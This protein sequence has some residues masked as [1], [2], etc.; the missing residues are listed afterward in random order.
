MSRLGYIS[1]IM[2]GHAKPP[3]L[4][5]IEAA[6]KSIYRPQILQLAA[7]LAYL[8][9][10]TSLRESASL[11][12]GQ[13]S[14]NPFDHIELTPIQLRILQ[15]EPETIEIFLDQFSDIFD[16]QYGTTELKEQYSTIELTDRFINLSRLHLHAAAAVLT[17]G[18]D[19]RGAVQS[20]LLASELALKSG[21]A[22]EGLTETRL[23]PAS[24]TA[25]PVWPILFPKPGRS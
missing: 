2:N 7:T 12:F 22:V 6:F 14:L 21:A 25:S 3:I 17:G 20:S 15:T 10:G 8:C 5:R 23:R 19:Y 18:Y 9:I 13:V 24:V 11:I 16:I 1:Y 4:D